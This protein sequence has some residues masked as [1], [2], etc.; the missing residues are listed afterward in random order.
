MLFNRGKR[1]WK[2]RVIARQM[3]RILMRSLCLLCG[4]F[5]IQCGWMMPPLILLRGVVYGWFI[6]TSVNRNSVIFSLYAIDRSRFIRQMSWWKI[7]NH[8]SRAR[9]FERVI[10]DSIPQHSMR[11]YS[12]LYRGIITIH[13]FTAATFYK[14]SLLV[15]GFNNKWAQIKAKTIEKKRV[16][17][18]PHIC[19]GSRS[20]AHTKRQKGT[21]CCPCINSLWINRNYSLSRAQSLPK[22]FATTAYNHPNMHHAVLEKNAKKFLSAAQFRYRIQKKKNNSRA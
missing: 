4:V 3:Y 2:W 22:C 5:I 7:S 8:L 11:V 13:S 19:T 14:I 16:H 12:S 20:P 1:E 21:T 10:Y 6:D 18:S 15:Y 9:L 17:L